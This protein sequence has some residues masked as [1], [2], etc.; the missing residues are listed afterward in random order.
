MVRAAGSLL[1]SPLGHVSARPDPRVQPRVPRPR[2]R[3]QA[4]DREVRGE[5]A[6]LHPAAEE[7][8]GGPVRV[9]QHEAHMSPHFRCDNKI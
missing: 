7:A 5:D 8:Q 9:R 6:Q 2:G 3:G 4:R 1:V